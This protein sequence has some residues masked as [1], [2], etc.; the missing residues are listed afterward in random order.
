V[1]NERVSIAR[2]HL[3]VISGGGGIAF[4]IGVWLGKIGAG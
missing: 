1:G 2:G 4:A 3:P